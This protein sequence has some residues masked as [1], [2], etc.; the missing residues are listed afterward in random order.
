MLY[1]EDIF[2]ALKKAQIDYVVVGGLATVLHGVV[3]MTADLD[4]VVALNQEN[5]TN[6]SKVMK[7]LGYKPKAPVSVEQL[8]D[9]KKRQEWIHE[10]NMQV[11]SFYHVTE[12]YK[13]IDVFITE[14]ISFNELNKAK[15]VIRVEDFEIPICSLEHLIEV[16]KKAGRPQDMADIKALKKLRK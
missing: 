13:L 1:F 10:K 11:F 8:G 14:P 2:K 3:R 16:K 5:I 15:K 4:L 9:P 12:H 7:N 6:F